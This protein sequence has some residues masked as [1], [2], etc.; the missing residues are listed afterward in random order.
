MVS[1]KRPMPFILVSANHGTMIVNRN[2]YCSN[3]KGHVWGV[4]Y[5]ILETGSH[6]HH[7]V[8]LILALLERRRRY[9]GNG[10]APCMDGARFWRSK[11][12]RKYSTPWPA[13]S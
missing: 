8:D 9:F 6:D 4:G 5:Q 13:T 7:E 11:P 2:D 1:I 12:R 10:R 3:G